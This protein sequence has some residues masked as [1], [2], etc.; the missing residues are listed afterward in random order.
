[1]AAAKV[2]HT[3]NEDNIEILEGLEAVRKR[4]G[5]YVGSTDSRGLHHL[6]WEILDNSIDEAMGG[7][8]TRISIT[9]HSDNSVTIQDEGR[10]VPT[11]MHKSGVPTPQVVYT[12]LHAGGKFNESAYGISAGLHGVGASVVTALS[13]FLNVTVYRDGKI[14][15]QSYRDG[16]KIID[17]AQ[18]LGN[19]NKTG[20]KV[21]FR[22]DPKIFST[23]DINRSLVAERIQESAFLL[24]GVELVLSDE[25]INKTE[26]YIYENGLVS[27]VE[28]INEGKTPYHPVTFIYGESNGIEVEIALQYV[29]DAYDETIYSYVNNI[30]TRDGGTHETGI[31]SGITR[32]LNDYARQNDLIK[33]KDRVDGSDY[34][35]GLTAIVSV[36]I[37]ET[38]LQFEGQTKGKLGTPDAKNAV[39]TVFYNKFSYYLIENKE[40]SAGII[41]RAINASSAR[42]A[43]RKARDSVRTNKKNNGEKLMAGKLTPAQSKNPDV[44]E[45]FLVEGDSAGGT[46]KQGRDRTFQA[47]LPLRGK[48]INSE[49]SSLED[50]LHNEEINSLVY[51]IGAGIGKDFISDDSKYGKIVIMTDADTDGAH[52]QVLLMTFFYRLMRPLIENG[53]VFLAMPPLYKVYKPSPKGEKFVY[54]WDDQELEQAK[55]TI[56][57]GALIQRYK[58]LGEMNA[59]QLWETTMN[60]LTRSLI[61]VTIDDAII[62]DRRVSILMGSDAGARR[63]WI[64]ENV[65]FTLEDHFK[66]K[67]DR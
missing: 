64:D 9:I 51:A 28:F 10:G 61:K 19:T 17:S 65:Q 40:I 33:E 18:F 54:A 11:G 57:N 52:I 12:V 56:G 63:N 29:K 21:H 66:V 58:G 4:P 25:R 41:E 1:M 38:L 15:F 62:A 7:F 23:I 22:P 49:K 14:F 37:P 67:G 48:V 44:L 16:G 35:E 24:K 20:T 42:D 2:V 5:M 43:A 27:Y 8:G 36:K 59:A 30:R 50:L 34:R 39:E 60:P 31:R 3:Y 53:K 47:I 26:Q 6:V 32:A 45:L 46:A 55:H 13:E